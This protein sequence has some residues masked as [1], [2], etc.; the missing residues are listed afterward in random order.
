MSDAQFKTGR[1]EGERID[2]NDCAQMQLWTKKLGI[3]PER[4]KEIVGI[5][6]TSI[7]DIRRQLG[8]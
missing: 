2:I 5:V 4:L 1:P 7:A 8:K 6:G 3:S